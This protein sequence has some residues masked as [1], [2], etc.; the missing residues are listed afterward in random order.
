MSS[1]NRSAAADSA[2]LTTPPAG[3]GVLSLIEAISMSSRVFQYVHSAHPCVV[4]REICENEI[5]W[6]S[7]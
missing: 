7:E 2:A 3:G 5:D 1:P 4:S 6:P